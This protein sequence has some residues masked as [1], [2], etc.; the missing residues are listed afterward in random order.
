MR[1]PRSG[2]SR[3]SEAE[4][5]AGGAE[6]RQHFAIGELADELGITTRT[7]RF[8]EA[9]G[10]LS[11]ERSGTTRIYTRRDRARLQ[12]ILRGK[13]LGFS[14]EDIAHYLD[15]YD[16]DPSQLT[17]TRMLLERIERTILDLQQKRS[18]IE[19]TLKELKEIRGQCHEHL[20]G[21]GGDIDT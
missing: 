12:L 20:K 21:Q 6:P 11:P 3:A 9:R 10:L 17:Q 19:R 2:K 16:T 8:Y 14:L 4:G 18:D 1:K 5:G 7:I 13:N 15:L